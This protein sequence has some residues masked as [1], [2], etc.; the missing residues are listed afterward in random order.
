MWW[1][2]RSTNIMSNRIYEDVQKVV[3]CSSAGIG[4]LSRLGSQT[5]TI[6]YQDGSISE[7]VWHWWISDSCPDFKLQE[8]FDLMNLGRS[9]KGLDTIEP[10]PKP[11][12][13]GKTCK[14]RFY[15]YKTLYKDGSFL[16]SNWSWVGANG[17]DDLGLVENWHVYFTPEEAS[18]YAFL[19]D[20]NNLKNLDAGTIIGIY[21]S[22]LQ[23]KCIGK[24]NS[25]L[26]S[27]A[28]SPQ[29]LEGKYDTGSQFWLEYWEQ[30][31]RDR[32]WKIRQDLR[33]VKLADGRLETGLRP[34]SELD[35]PLNC[36]STAGQMIVLI[37]NAITF[38]AGVPPAL[39][40]AFDLPYT[41]IS[42]RDIYNKL[43]LSSKVQFTLANIASPVAKEFANLS[44]GL[45]SS[46]SGSSDSQ[47]IDGRQTNSLPLLGILVLGYYL[48]S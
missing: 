48:L 17:G 13:S 10:C 45:S 25:V 31:L 37:A 8:A 33:Q 14:R 24:I 7:G 22:L 12:V 28:A 27:S 46:G 34:P 35:V 42:F 32:I 23:R 19:Q 9:D 3:P 21:Y 40:F 30:G 20:D 41:L 36:Q 44:S 16:E 1:K 29:S 15:P 5:E 4:T 38:L 39:Q 18:V 26:S 6:N 11:D 43:T 2:K 47:P